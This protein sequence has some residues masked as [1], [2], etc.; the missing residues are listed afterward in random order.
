MFTMRGLIV[1]IAVTVLNSSWTANGE[2]WVK[3]S[4]PALGAR[5][6]KQQAADPVKLLQ[7]IADGNAALMNQL[8]VLEQ[9]QRQQQAQLKHLNSQQDQMQEQYRESVNER[10]FLK[11]V[12][13]NLTSELANS[14]RVKLVP[15]G[16]DNEQAQNFEHQLKQ[17]VRRE[18]QAMACNVSAEIET[19]SNALQAVTHRLQQLDTQHGDLD[20]K[21]QSLNVVMANVEGNV[22]ENLKAAIA[23]QLKQQDIQ[24]QHRYRMLAV[25][26]QDQNTGMFFG[27]LLYPLTYHLFTTV[28]R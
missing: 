26:I 1:V 12:I 4:A 28:H 3:Q 15:A 27:V 5:N 6:H 8:M 16:D 14:N 11:Q 10:Q 17:R 18:L 23:Q 20:Q 25:A 2:S 7:Q 21:L 22:T 13:S 9:Q 24:E 19:V